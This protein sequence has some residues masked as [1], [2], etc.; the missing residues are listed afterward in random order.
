M[1]EVNQSQESLQLALSVG[2]GKFPYD[3]HLLIQWA[4]A[5]GVNMVAKEVQL[6]DTKATLGDID[7]DAVLFQSLEN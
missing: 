3:V 6:C 5:C 7:N 2:E 4:Y 1:V